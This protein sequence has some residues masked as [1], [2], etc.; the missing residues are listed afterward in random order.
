MVYEKRTYTKTF[1][2]VRT[3]RKA[4]EWSVTL[5]NP[6]KAIL[7]LEG[8]A[9]NDPYARYLIVRVNDK[10]ILKTIVSRYF[11][12][13][14]D[15]SRYVRNGPNRISIILTTYVGSWSVTATLETEEE[16]GLFD[17]NRIFS[18]INE[19]IEKIQKGKL[20]EALAYTGYALSV[21]LAL[22]PYAIAGGELA[23]SELKKRGYIK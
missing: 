17:I 10:Q 18:F 23:Y 20:E 6:R 9:K 21:P 8:K 22:L 19:L 14:K 16:V 15:I 1:E 5:S 11:K 13:T 2:F 7:K 4:V 3:G 12:I